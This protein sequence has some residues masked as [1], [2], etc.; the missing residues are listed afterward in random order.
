MDQDGDTLPAVAVAAI[1]AALLLV[2]LDAEVD[3]IG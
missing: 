2:R 3:P 1:N